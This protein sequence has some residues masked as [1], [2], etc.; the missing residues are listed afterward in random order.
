MATH[1]ARM[2]DRLRKRGADWTPKNKPGAGRRPRDPDRVDKSIRMPAAFWRFLDARYGT[3]PT[4]GD[5][6]RSMIA[7]MR[8]RDLHHPRERNDPARVVV[9]VVVDPVTRSAA[10]ARVVRADGAWKAGASGLVATPAAD[11]IAA[12]TNDADRVAIECLSLPT[13]LSRNESAAAGQVRGLVVAMA[14]AVG[15]EVDDVPASRATPTAVR[16]SIAAAGVPSTGLSDLEDRA[17]LLAIL[18]IKAAGLA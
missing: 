2:V 15:A 18:S 3:D 14:Q 10:F 17:H 4:P 8:D 1:D 16:E 12:Y 6:V 5:Q 13:D 7:E 9:G 11:D